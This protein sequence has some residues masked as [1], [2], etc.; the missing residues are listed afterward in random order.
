MY[1]ESQSIQFNSI[2]K[3]PVK[4]I[5]KKNILHAGVTKSCACADSSTNTIQLKVQS[6]K[7]FWRNTVLQLIIHK[8]QFLAEPSNIV[9]PKLTCLNRFATWLSS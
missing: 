3:N 4:N 9:E 8:S 6:F 1:H 2:Y 7:C 5:F